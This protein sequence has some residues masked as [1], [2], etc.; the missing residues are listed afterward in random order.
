[1][2]EDYKSC[3]LYA[4]DEGHI[5]MNEECPICG[6]AHN[7]EYAKKA[8]DGTLYW[9]CPETYKKVIAIYA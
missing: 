7:D 6:K 8:P 3:G 5:V 2:N 1:M 4:D 9:I